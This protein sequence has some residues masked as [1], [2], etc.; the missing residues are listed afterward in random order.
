MLKIWT[1]GF[2]RMQ[3]SDLIG[4]FLPAGRFVLTIVNWVSPADSLSVMAWSLIASAVFQTDRGAAHMLVS[5][6]ALR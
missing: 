4:V 2:A 3:T 5:G 1:A 6:K